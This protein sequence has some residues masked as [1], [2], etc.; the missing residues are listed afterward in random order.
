M[1]AH[2]N[3]QNA[4]PAFLGFFQSIVL[5]SGN[6]RSRFFIRVSPGQFFNRFSIACFYHIS[7]LGGAT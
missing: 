7:T 2:G 5:A 4:R 6:D 3:G 1:I